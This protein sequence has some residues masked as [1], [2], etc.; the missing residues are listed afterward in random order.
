MT[1]KPQPEDTSPEPAT[2]SH[3]EPR[4]P[5]QDRPGAPI[6]TEAIPAPAQDTPKPATKGKPTKAR[7][8]PGGH[9]ARRRRVGK[10][11]LAVTLKPDQARELEQLTARVMEPEPHDIAAGIVYGMPDIPDALRGAPV[12]DQAIMLLHGLG[13]SPE[14]ISGMFRMARSSV[15]YVLAHYMPQ[16]TGFT[17]AP[18][19]ARL[20]RAAM[21]DAAADKLHA[22]VMGRDWSEERAVDVAKV[23]QFYRRNAADARGS[24]T[25][26]LTLDPTNTVLELTRRE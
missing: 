14:T 12:R 19:Q 17:L 13:M 18:H 23:E 2:R 21:Y 25:A 5:A 7:P 20:V 22:H 11:E 8:R 16:G 6:D 10:A 15:G 1:T 9:K 24:T 26:R 4:N 3:Q